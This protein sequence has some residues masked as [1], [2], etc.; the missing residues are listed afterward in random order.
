M[1]GMF[2]REKST[3]YAL[4]VTYNRRSQSTHI[5][6]VNVDSSAK[7]LGLATFIIGHMGDDVDEYDAWSESCA[8]HFAFYALR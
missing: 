6:L 2:H 3:C 7:S 4:D 1:Q 8:R 5:H